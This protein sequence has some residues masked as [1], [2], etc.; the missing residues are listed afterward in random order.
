VRRYVE[1]GDEEGGYENSRG[2]L[3][4]NVIYAGA[5]KLERCVLVMKRCLDMGGRP[6]AW[7]EVGK[8]H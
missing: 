8:M 1:D 4:V 2:V 6:R 7:T 3:R 5:D